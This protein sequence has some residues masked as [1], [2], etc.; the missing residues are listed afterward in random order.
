MSLHRRD[1]LF[2][3]ATGA[4]RLIASSPLAS[5]P[6]GPERPAGSAG[7]TGPA[8]TGEET[9]PAG[10]T[11]LT[12]LWTRFR[13][14]RELGR[15]ASPRIL[16]PTLAARTRAVRGLAS[17]SGRRRRSG[18]LLVGARYAEYT[19]WM[20]QEAGDL[21]AAE[22]WTSLAV[23]MAAS[24][25]ETDMAAYAFVRRGL[26][27]L[28]RGDA[29]QTIDLARRAQSGRLP[30][31]IRGL[32]AQREAQGHALAG[33]YRQCRDALDRA[34]A[35]FARADAQRPDP[36]ALGTPALVPSTS[37]PSML[38][39]STS[40]PSTSGPSTSGP[41]T[42]GPSTSGP[43]ML[44]PSTL[45]DPVAVV[46]GWCLFDLARPGESA[47]LLEREIAG[48]PTTARRARARYGVR[49]ARAHAAA[50]EVDRACAL[51]GALLDD[52]AAV[53]SATVRVDL[54]LLART[55]A[56]WRQ[57]GPV[58][59]LSPRLAGALRTG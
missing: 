52:I 38:G 34:A 42:S 36:P 2:V 48:L 44:G 51:T 5:S 28:Y 55:L 46:T 41:S 54:R 3:G 25:G 31:R 26:I 43:S 4:L 7:S 15:V 30:E 21:A 58:R 45:A 37:G 12:T 56:R 9:A 18:L 14:D 20:T 16:L 8:W 57:H 29:R 1:V 11:T 59:E 35:S 6:P 27:A 39:P 33:S 22:W 19:G 23:R 47:D 50:G 40:G 32:A 53:D 10:G 17:A 49:L 24:A 13:Q